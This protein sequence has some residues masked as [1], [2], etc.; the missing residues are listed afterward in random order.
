MTLGMAFEHAEQTPQLHGTADEAR[1]HGRRGL[2]IER[3]EGLE[4]HRVCRV[5][6]R[7]RA[8]AQSTHVR[9]Q[10]AGRD[11]KGSEDLT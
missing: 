6:C 5:R 4:R 9:A 11:A 10:G 2:L 3:I 8:R 7:A 1:L